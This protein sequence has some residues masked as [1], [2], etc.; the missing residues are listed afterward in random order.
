MLF[1]CS[2]NG[3]EWYRYVIRFS[4]DIFNILDVVFD[5]LKI[6]IQSFTARVLGG[7]RVYQ[8]FSYLT[9]IFP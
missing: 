4:T 5:R 1:I 3:F 8:E 9:C 7:Y 6:A 2:F